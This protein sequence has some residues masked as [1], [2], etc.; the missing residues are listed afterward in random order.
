MPIVV[1]SPGELSAL[2]DLLDE[3]EVYRKIA[4]FSV[5]EVISKRL[6]QKLEG[7]LE[8][9]GL[10][11]TKIHDM[12]VCYFNDPGVPDMIDWIRKE[13][14]YLLSNEVFLDAFSYMITW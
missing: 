6:T 10:V 1:E 9:L 7:T 2:F 5:Y 4:M 13:I 3:A 14:H 12:E 8:K 11:C